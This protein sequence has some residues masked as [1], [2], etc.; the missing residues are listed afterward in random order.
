MDTKAKYSTNPTHIAHI[1]NKAPRL[2]GSV[3][4]A[5][6]MDDRLRGGHFMLY[7][8]ARSGTGKGGMEAM[9]AS[10]QNITQPCPRDASGQLP[11]GSGSAECAAQNPDEDAR[12]LDLPSSS[13]RS[14]PAVSQQTRDQG[15]VAAELAKS[16][17]LELERLRH[18]VEPRDIFWKQLGL[19]ISQLQL[20][21]R[22]RSA[23]GC[24]RLVDGPAELLINGDAPEGWSLQRL[25]GPLERGRKGRRQQQVT[26]TPLSQESGDDSNAPKAVPFPAAQRQQ[27]AQS[28]LQR[29]STNQTAAQSQAAETA[30]RKAIAQAEQQAARM[31][32]A[33]AGTAPESSLVTREPASEV[34][35]PQ[36]PAISEP[37]ACLSPANETVVETGGMISIPEPRGIEEIQAPGGGSRRNALT[38]AGPKASRRKKSSKTPKQISNSQA[39]SSRTGRSIRIPARLRDCV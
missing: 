32:Q 25:K 33:C 21:I 26:H 20:S 22:K 1:P 4:V 7:L 37:Q 12:H 17:L 15:Q 19:E 24:S 10:L 9:Y 27:R 2:L 18:S 39:T 28:I 36:Q 16:M 8:G 30:Q 13:G 31:Q 11:S 23:E 34:A 38:S 3:Q 6:M 29:V 5:L 14:A 35:L